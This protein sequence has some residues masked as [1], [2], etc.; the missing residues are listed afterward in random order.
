MERGSLEQLQY[1]KRLR[2]RNGWISKAQEQSYIDALPD[3]SDKI[4]IFIEE[5]EEEPEAQEQVVE[6]PVGVP[7]DPMAEPADTTVGT[8]VDPLSPPPFREV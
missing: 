5:E 1:D 7:S 6:A 4:F 2:L 3:V 8:P